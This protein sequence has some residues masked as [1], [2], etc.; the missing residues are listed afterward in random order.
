MSL[1]VMYYDGDSVGFGLR[2][3]QT[4]DSDTGF[5]DLMDSKDVDFFGLSEEQIIAIAKGEERV[6]GDLRITVDKVRDKVLLQYG[7]KSKR[8]VIPRRY[9]GKVR[10][11]IT[12]AVDD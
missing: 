11:E 5:T 2:Y 6:C 10:R 8:M 1:D 3:S 4:D 12:G 7:T 9:L